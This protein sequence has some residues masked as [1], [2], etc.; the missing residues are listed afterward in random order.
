LNN[1]TDTEL[2][3]AARSGDVESLGR[4]Y[5]R[6]YQSMAWV[7]YSVLFDRDQAQDI[8][9][10][11]FAVACRKLVHLKKP[12]RFSGWLATICRNLAIDTL[13]RRKGNGVSLEEIDEPVAP[14]R[15]DEGESVRQAISRLPEM[16]REIVVLRY[17]DEMSYEQLRQ[18]LGI[19]IHAVKGR[20]FRAKQRLRTHMNNNGS[21]MR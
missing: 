20:L 5:N 17:F 12:E 1:Q 3:E 18:S 7:A 6:Y 10:E 14:D 11:T 2:V 8:A 4:L 13:R 16:D 15:G 19:S 9:Q 21:A